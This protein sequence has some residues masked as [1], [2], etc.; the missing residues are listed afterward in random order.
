MAG[1]EVEDI[2]HRPGLFRPYHRLEERMPPFEENFVT[3]IVSKATT[4]KRMSQHRKHKTHKTDN[5]THGDNMT[6]DFGHVDL[7]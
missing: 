7:M 1:L 5:G 2:H 4:R 3:D 6:T